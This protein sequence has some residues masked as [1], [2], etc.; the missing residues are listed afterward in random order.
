[1]GFNMNKRIKP[2]RAIE[3]LEKVILDKQSA[4]DKHLEFCE[5][6]NLCPECKYRAQVIGGLKAEHSILLKY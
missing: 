5:R 3:C 1:M 4:L 2:I 6:P